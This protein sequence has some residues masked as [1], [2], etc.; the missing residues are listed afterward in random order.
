[1]KRRLIILVLMLCLLV[2]PVLIFS[3]ELYSMPPS[4]EGNPRSC[5]APPCC[6]T[7]TNF[8]TGGTL[9]YNS[10]TWDFGDGTTPVIQI[11][12][13]AQ[14]GATVT[15]CY[16]KAGIFTVTLTMEDAEGV[17]AYKVEFDY[18]MVGTDGGGDTTTWSFDS[19]GCF[20]KHLPDSFFGSAQL[21][22]LS[23]VPSEVQG[24][25]YNNFGTWKFWAPRAPGTT[26]ATLVGGL[27][28]D[29]LV[30]VTGATDWDI[31]LISD[32]PP[33]MFELSPLSISP[34]EAFCGQ[35]VNISTTVSNTG[36]DG[37]YWAELELNEAVVDSKDIVITGGSSTILTFSV[38]RDIPGTYNVQIGNRKGSFTVSH[39]PLN[40]ML[41]YVGVTYDKNPDG[42]GNIFLLVIV[43]DG[44]N[45]PNYFSIPIEGLPDYEISNYDTEHVG[46]TVFTS[47]CVGDYFDI[48]VLAYHRVDKSSL[49]WGTIGGILSA[50]VGNPL[51]GII[52]NVIDLINNA[53]PD[54]KLVGYYTERWSGENSW[55]IGQHNCVGEDDLRLWFR[56]WADSPPEIVSQPFVGSPN[57]IIHNVDIPS[58]WPETYWNGVY[59]INGR[60]DTITLKNGESHPVDVRVERVSSTNPETVYTYHA[61]VPAN[62]YYDIKKIFHY[63]PVGL[64]SITIKLFCNNDELD[65]WSGEVNVIPH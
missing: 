62:N 61:T 38:A 48:A 14:Y 36:G 24:V 11:D 60:A 12:A 47:L 53:G 49:P 28:A 26:L 41:D 44:T 43:D 51:L 4:F 29:Y 31:P 54:Y 25:Y 65:S 5:G 20:P 10:A 59:L 17:M 63:T 9:P 37:I 27:S 34:Q 33:P 23:G 2:Q 19:S 52:G 13:N 16:Q 50:L 15:H 55:G 3:S 8:M 45:L 42:P 21:G 32:I 57:V 64:R 56:I 30:C 1:M 22:S 46:K 40:V 18:I 58:E 6:V 39:P 35:T 7:F